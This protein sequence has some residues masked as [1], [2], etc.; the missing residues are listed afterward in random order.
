MP[1]GNGENRSF[2]SEVSKASRIG[3]AGLL[4]GSVF[5]PKDA[6][7]GKVYTKY[8]E[9]PSIVKTFDEQ[10]EP[11]QFEKVSPVEYVT[12]GDSDS[13]L[14]EIEKEII[15][16]RGGIF[17]DKV[18]YSFAVDSPLGAYDKY[19]NFYS[20]SIPEGG[21]LNVNGA[22]FKL[23]YETGYF[24]EVT[25]LYAPNEDT[26]VAGQI[27]PYMI[28]LPSEAYGKSFRVVNYADSPKSIERDIYTDTREP[29]ATYL[30]MPVITTSHSDILPPSVDENGNIVNRENKSFN[31]EPG[32]TT[33]STTGYLSWAFMKL[34]KDEG[35]DY[36]NLEFLGIQAP[37]SD[38]KLYM[39]LD[40]APSDIIER[41]NLD[42]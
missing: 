32:G 15:E 23:T 1:T 10:E 28:F 19:G 42:K 17:L 40:N 18:D 24:D 26:L 16:K 37:S 22:K 20:N 2:G 30:V 9:N 36:F 13:G 34:T 39:E 38:N 6:D 7:I 31:I 14:S 41:C 5:T 27:F 8:A 33:G 35:N 21:I 29:G 11:F 25:F 4:L 12:L 3:T